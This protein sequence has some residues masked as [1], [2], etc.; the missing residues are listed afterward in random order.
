MLQVIKKLKKYL[1]NGVGFR[2]KIMG[3]ALAL[4]LVFGFWSALQV[5]RATG[6]ALNIYLER[7]GVSTAK[8][9]A[10]R[11]EDYILTNNLYQ[12]HS[13]INDTLDNN[14]DVR[15]LFILGTDNAVIS[16]SFPLSLP[17]GLR[18][19]NRLEEAGG[20]NLQTIRTEEGLIDDI[21]VPILNGRAGTV[22]LG[23]SQ[24]SG[25]IIVWNIVRQI[26]LATVSLSVLGFIGAYILTSLIF[27]PINDLVAATEAVGSGDFSIKLTPRANDEVGKLTGAFNLMTAR[28]HKLRQEGM[29]YRKQLERKDYLRLQLQEKII[30]TQEEE[31]KRISRE[32]HD[33][34]GQ[35][36]TSLKLLLKR[37][38]EVDSLEE[39]KTIVQETRSLL[40]DTLKGVRALSR[41][42]RPSVLDDLGLITAL[43][44]YLKE[45]AERWALTIDLQVF[46]LKD[47]QPAPYMAIS[48]Y[49]II[50]EAVTNV[51]K[52]ARAA[53]VSII[54]E[55]SAENI[56]A[57]IEDDGVGFDMDILTNP[58]SKEV[59]LGIFGMQE[60]A[61][62]IGGELVV[63]SWPGK[64]TTLYLKIPLEEKRGDLE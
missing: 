31:R 21:A 40:S 26:L 6:S 35:S 51:A 45:C 52:H 55:K 54:V 19:V 44:R 58:D 8:A 39:V 36:L 30:S 34:T 15:Y 5:Y 53:N 38:E 11:S 37:M 18:E 2:G 61:L 59:G 16:S 7:A 48:I 33:E 14:P 22:R 60:R 3:I 4:V 25:R 13:L 27:K 50:Q 64:G 1:Q 49:R 20:H 10:A 43:E 63:E 62:L 32:L 57:I 56:V 9:V 47:W 42:L 17:E 29:D 24:T 23:I 28:L 46:G 12:L 41:D